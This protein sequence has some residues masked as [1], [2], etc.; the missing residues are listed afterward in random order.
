M[1]TVLLLAACLALGGRAHG[2]VQAPA[3]SFASWVPQL[4]ADFGSFGLT[5]S[6]EETPVH[7]L[8]GTRS[9]TGTGLLIGG[10]VGAAASTVFLI[11]FCG[12]PDTSCGIDEVG[13]ATLFIAVPCAAAGALIGSL[14]RTDG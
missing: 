6:Q 5:A 3:A 13:R 14:V 2:Q 8:A 10:I 11:G 7:R 9:H 1:R 4:P 12:D